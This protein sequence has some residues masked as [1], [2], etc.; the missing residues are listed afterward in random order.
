M[1]IFLFTTTWGLFNLFRP[2]INPSSVEPYPQQQEFKESKES[3]SSYEPLAPHPHAGARYPDGKYGYV[4][5][6]TA[7]RNRHFQL[8]NA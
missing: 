3:R 7:V 8:L 5:D 4:A 2:N 6:V 1:L